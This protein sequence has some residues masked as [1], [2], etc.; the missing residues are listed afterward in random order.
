MIWRAHC[1]LMPASG[2]SSCASC[3]FCSA[4]RL[5]PPALHGHK[6]A[7][8]Q[9]SLSD[10]ARLQPAATEETPLWTALE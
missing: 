7:P 1:G 5:E 9:I 4:T 6:A 2:H 8:L 10:K 3:K